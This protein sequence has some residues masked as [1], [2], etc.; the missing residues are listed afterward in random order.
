MG[1]IRSYKCKIKRLNNNKDNHFDA[2]QH[3]N[4]SEKKT[5]IKIYFISFY[6]IRCP[7]FKK[8]N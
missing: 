1:V 4:E 2:K 8:V 3:S 6:P 7:T 5:K